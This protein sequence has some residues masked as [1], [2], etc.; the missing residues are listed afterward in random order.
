MSTIWL[1]DTVVVT[2]KLRREILEELDELVR[3]GYFSSRSEAIRKAI[4]ELL[5]HYSEERKGT[6]KKAQLKATALR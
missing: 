2:F 3:K 6:V 5:N 1:D 4:I